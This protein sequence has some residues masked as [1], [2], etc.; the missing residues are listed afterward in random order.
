VRERRREPRYE[1]ERENPTNP[2]SASI[3]FRG[4]KREFVDCGRGST[5]AKVEKALKKPWDAQE[6]DGWVVG[7]RRFEG[8]GMV[9]LPSSRR[10][11]AM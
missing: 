7:Y 5:K 3:F 10:S 1:R 4:R 8:N 2:D 11:P 9:A 6:M